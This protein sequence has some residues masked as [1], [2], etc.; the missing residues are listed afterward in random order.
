MKKNIKNDLVHFINNDG[1]IFSIRG[2]HHPKGFIVACPLYF[3]DSKGIR[4]GNK[5]NLRFNKCLDQSGDKI[6]NIRPSYICNKSLPFSIL[7]PEKDVVEYFDPFDDKSITKIKKSIEGGKWEKVIS[8]IK[9]IGI[10]EKD[11]GIFGSY[12]LDLNNKDSDLD[13]LVRGIDNQKIV[14]KNILEIR[15]IINAKDGFNKKILRETI[16]RYNKD[17]NLEHNDFIK[18]LKKRWSLI[19][20]DEE[21][22]FIKIHFTY[23]NNEIPNFPRG[24]KIKSSIVLKGIVIDNSDINYMP[25]KFKVKANYKTYDIYTYFWNFYYCVNTNDKVIIYGDLCNDDKT[26]ILKDPKNHG[27]KFNK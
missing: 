11:I 27:I 7:V 14:K 12:L 24:V 9:K 1:I 22:I 17:Y 21:D 8:S 15:K 16:I 5:F 10:K 4:K 13:I 19:R 26:I 18:M 3:P 23:K 25:R 6:K 2:Y 20:K